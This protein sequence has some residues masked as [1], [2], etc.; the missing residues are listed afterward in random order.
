MRVLLTILLTAL[1]MPAVGLATGN[2][3][4][5]EPLPSEKLGKTKRPDTE[6][7]AWAYAVTLAQDDST[8]LTPDLQIAAMLQ[9]STI[10][11]PELMHPPF[12]SLTGEPHMSVT[13]W[14]KKKL[15]DEA[16]FILSR[17]FASLPSDTLPSAADPDTLAWSADSDSLLLEDPLPAD[18]AMRSDSLSDGSSASQTDT[19]GGFA[20]PEGRWRE[21]GGPFADMVELPAAELP[22][23][24]AEKDTGREVPWT[25]GFMI[26]RTEV[27]NSQYARFL[28][29]IPD[30]E[31][32]YE[33]E[34]MIR[35][36][37]DGS[38]NPVEGHETFPV[39][40]VSWHDAMAY[41]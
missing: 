28:S 17:T 7:K 36:N 6:R 35:K 2:M 38:Y 22:V 41:A 31:E 37:R 14:F 3:P 39:N 21:L 12:D 30:A 10:V 8:A 24:H 9:D 26:D 16:V 40:Y 19:A 13:V 34:M 18:S 29:S 4:G 25:P 33:S 1:W 15:P 5:T 32:H 23:I 20:W 27:T 11:F